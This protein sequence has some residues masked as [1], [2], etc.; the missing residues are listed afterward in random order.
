[1]SQSKLGQAHHVRPQWRSRLGFILAAIGSAVG[2]GNIWRFSYLCYKNGGGAFLVPYL[3]ALFMVGIPL[4]ILELGLGHKTRGSAPMAFAKIDRRWEWLGWWSVII[5]MF[6]IMLYYS[7][8]IAWCLSYVFYSFTLAWGSDPNHFFF[9]EYLKVSGGPFEFGDLRT[10]VIF[11]LVGVWFTGWLIVFFGVDKGVE[12]ANKIFM[13]LLLVL[14]LVLVFWSVNLEGAGIGL[15][16]YLSPDFSRLTSPG[17]WIDAFS[18]IFF[19]LSLGF[20]IM[21][22]YASYL[23]RKVDIVKD[24]LFI[25]F[26]NALFSLVA[27]FAVFGTLG[28]MSHTTGQPIDEVVK[29][30]IGL[31]FVAYPQAISLMPKFAQVFGVLFFLSLVIAGI[32]SAISILEA[33]ASALIDKFNLGRNAIVTD[34]CIMGFLGSLIFTANSGLYWLDIADHYITHY[35]LVAV[36][37]FECYVVG[38]IYEARKMRGHINH[39]EP[40]SLTKLWD[41][42]VKFLTPTVLVAL[43]ANDLWVEFREP[44]GG[45]PVLSLVV[46]GVLWVVITVMAALLVAGKPWKSELSEKPGH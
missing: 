44:Y 46:I 3:L 12:R 24:A 28:Y 6:G 36:G 20:G 38:W 18:Q 41:G 30:A 27:G 29:E 4:M 17:I 21:I 1:M 40:D 43:V 34:I 32:S 31:A 10:P 45:Y 7:T 42:C 35:G 39:C 22:T 23:P 9:Q 8:V 15:A 2:L 37:V 13:P 16:A 14:I 25:S 11:S 33:F 19:T 26:G 5:V